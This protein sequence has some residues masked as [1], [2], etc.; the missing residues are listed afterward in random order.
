VYQHPVSEPLAAKAPSL[1]RDAIARFWKGETFP[2]YASVSE[3]G[4]EKVDGENFGQVLNC[5]LVARS[6]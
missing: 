5:L 6:I 2:I 1:Y 3:A 4:L